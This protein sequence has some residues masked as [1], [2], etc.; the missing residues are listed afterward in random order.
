ME[1]TTKILLIV[2]TL[3]LCSCAV[4]QEISIDDQNGDQ[5]E[6]VIQF[7]DNISNVRATLDDRLIE[8]RSRLTK[9]LRLQNINPGVYTLRVT[10][11]SWEL[12]DNLNFK[13]DVTIRSGEQSAVIISVPPKSGG[14]WALQAVTLAISLSF[15]LRHTY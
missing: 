12:K 1:T 2:L 15:A 10:A 4:T 14:Y 9:E 13:R 5:G 11:A 3:S 7:S 6:L 8:T